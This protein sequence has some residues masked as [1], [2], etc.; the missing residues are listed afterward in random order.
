MNKLKRDVVIT[1]I[2]LAF[3]TLAKAY[4]EVIN[5]PQKDKKIYGS[6]NTRLYELK[7]KL[8]PKIVESRVYWLDKKEVNWKEEIKKW[9]F[10]F[11]P[12]DEFLPPLVNY[13]ENFYPLEEKYQDGF[14]W[15]SNNARLLVFNLIEKPI[16]ADFEFEALS[17]KKDRQLEIWVNG[18]RETGID[19]TADK[20]EAE[21]KKFV[22]KG[23]TLNPGENEIVFYT[24]EGTDKLKP[25]GW[26]K[27]KEREVSIKFKNFSFQV[28]SKEELLKKQNE[29]Q[30]QYSYIVTDDGLVLTVYFKIEGQGF[31][32]MSRDVSINLEE[33]PYLSLDYALKENNANLEVFLGIDH[34]GDGNIDGYLNPGF[35]EEINLFELAK[36]KWSE[37]DYFRYGFILKKIIVLIGFYNEEIQEEQIGIL[38]FKNMNF[39]NEKSLILI[40]QEFGKKELKFENVNVKSAILGDN[41]EINI[42]SYF[43]G[44][45]VRIENVSIKEF[46][47][48]IENKKRENEEVRVYLP[49]DKNLVED[50]PHLSFNY[51]FD[52]PQV[53]EIKLYLSIQ[54]DKGNKNF[55]PLDKDNYQETGEVL[56]ANLKEI[57]KKFNPEEL[58]IRLKRKNNVDCSLESNKGWYGFQLSN[59]YLYTKFPYP[60][61]TVQL[62]DRFSSLIHRINPGLVKIDKEVFNLN[63]FNWQNF[64]GLERG[65]LVK[66]IRLA[67]GNHKYEKLKNATFSV[68]WAILE[69]NPKSQFPISKSE[70]EITFKKINPTKYLVKVEGAKGPFWLVFSESFHKQWHL[71]QFPIPNSQFP[72]F[73]EIVADY[74]ELKVKEAKHLMRF[75]PQDIKYLFGKPLPAGHYLVNGYANGWY[76]EPKKLGLGKDFVLVIYFWPQSLFYLGLFVSGLTFL[77]CITYLIYNFIRRKKCQDLNY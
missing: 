51:K 56:S 49:L 8:K 26:E 23:I 46:K 77:S 60:V 74:P 42:V 65:V 33:Y 52:N 13:K 37:A 75:T 25:R 39:Y 57:F 29:I 54:D 59:I 7:V 5:L 15:M 43:D 30:P 61:K 76:I 72:K 63:D 2:F 21:F 32:L 55:V 22:I 73:E 48:S 19:I 36:E 67:K 62:K 66:K 16:K 68:E 20:R 17:H 34:N 58:I 1:L 14:R 28:K 71:Y 11:L 44:A 35:L 45:P 4:A 40:G 10:G 9:N 3:V 50:F 31:L 6:L 69:P 18:K 47:G 27:K 41:E 53:Q 12:E 70:P 38:N 64:D 24:P